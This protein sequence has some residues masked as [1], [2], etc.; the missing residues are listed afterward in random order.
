MPPDA[1]PPGPVPREQ[2]FDRLMM[3]VRISVR[4]ADEAADRAYHA[5]YSVEAGRYKVE[6]VD[7]ERSVYEDLTE[8]QAALRDTPVEPGR[9][10]AFAFVRVSD[11]G[12][13]EVDTIEE[14]TIRIKLESIQ[15]ITRKEPRVYLATSGATAVSCPPHLR[16][17]LDRMHDLYPPDGTRLVLVLIEDAPRRTGTDPPEANL[18]AI[19]GLW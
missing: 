3:H 9:R 6:A 8:V 13:G 17:K 2:E 5:G 7:W 12:T 19:V 1:M 18:P 4:E 15:L 11:A 10:F 14:I 16:A